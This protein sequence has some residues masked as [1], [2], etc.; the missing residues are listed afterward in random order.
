MIPPK[1]LDKLERKY[2]V[3]AIEGNPGDI[4]FFHASLVHGSTHNTSPNGR[5]VIVSRINSMSNLPKNVNKKAILFNLSRA[6]KEYKEAQRK[7]K[8]FKK[9]YRDQQK[10][11]KLT[12]LP[13]IVKEE[14]T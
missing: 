5:M 12:F 7:L 3:K 13:P 6:K 1:K 8:W 9:K 11:T 4:L 2:G 10:S 14:K